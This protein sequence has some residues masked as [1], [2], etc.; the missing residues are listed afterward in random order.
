MAS[1][2]VH[3]M[4][5]VSALRHYGIQATAPMFI[6]G[7]GALVRLKQYPIDAREDARVGLAGPVWGCA[8][9][10]VA[11]VLGL[12]LHERTAL[13]VASLGATINVFNLVPVWQLDGARGFRALDTRQRGIVVTLAA[14]AALLS[15]D[16]M[17]WVVC[18]VGGVRLKSNLPAEGDSRAFRT[19][20]GLI[21]VLTAIAWA[22]GRAA[23][24]G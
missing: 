10:A 21:V 9:A 12:V 16:A 5:H 2:Y 17:G 23:A 20:A 14:V 1:I 8:A 11:L 22:A 13:A 24:E 4:G 19:F 6:P 7:L 15:G 3:E 18:A